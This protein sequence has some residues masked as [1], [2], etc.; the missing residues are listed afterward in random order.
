MFDKNLIFVAENYVC[1][2]CG[3]VN[4]DVMLMPQF[5]EVVRQ[6]VLGVVVILPD[7]LLVISQAF[8]R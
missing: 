2:N 4:N 7:A 1:K 6:H 5:L 3:D 8:H